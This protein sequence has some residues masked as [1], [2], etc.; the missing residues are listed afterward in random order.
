MNSCRTKKFHLL[1]IRLLSMKELNFMIDIKK[2][3]AVHI[4][5]EQH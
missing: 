5:A 3:G 1:N 2:G 4:D